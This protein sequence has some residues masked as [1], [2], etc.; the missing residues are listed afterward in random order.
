M[1]M[2]DDKIKCVLDRGLEHWDHCFDE[3]CG[4]VKG[5]KPGLFT[6]EWLKKYFT[7]ESSEQLHNYPKSLGYATGLFYAG[8]QVDRANRIVEIFTRNAQ[9]KDESNPDYGQLFWFLEEKCIRDRNA[10]FFNASALFV[11]YTQFNGLL[12]EGNRKTVEDV[13]RRL[14]PVFEKEREE[15]RWVY[16]N[17]SLGKFALCSLLSEIFDLPE[18]QSD[19]D[20]FAEFADFLFE[21]GVSETLT[22]TYVTVDLEILFICLLGS[23]APAMI[24]KARQLLL[25]IFLKQT[26]FFGNRFPAPFRRGYNGEYSTRRTDG[27]P[28]LMG[29]RNLD[30]SSQ[31]PSPMMTAI[32][33]IIQTKY[34]DL[35]KDEQDGELPRTLHTKVH[36]DCIAV[37]YLDKEYSLGSFNYYPPE[38]TN[39][40]TVDIGGSGWQD[41]I[42]Y[43]TLQ[44]QECTSCILRLEAIDEA[45]TERFHPYEGEYLQE[46]TLRLYPHLSFPP[47]PQIRCNQQGGELLCIYK[48]DSID[49]VLR[50]FGFNLHFSRFNGKLFDIS[51]C[52][53]NMTSA[54]TIHMGAVIMSIDG[55]FVMLVP[56]ARVDM[57]KSE[58]SH[59]SFIEPEF[60][61]NYRN[62]G[63]DCAMYNYNGEA[64]RFTL[65]HVSGG[66]FLSVAKDTTLDKFLE[67]ARQVKI[68]DNWFFD[69][70]TPCIDQ[71]GCTRKTAAVSPKTKLHLEWNHFLGVRGER[72]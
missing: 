30:S 26:C 37:S 2:T 1:H 25:Q 32:W 54:G 50:R 60:T 38:T 7:V 11:I 72:V 42:V 18:K 36:K 70:V 33:S 66:F 68:S 46:K 22:P 8:K 56:L 62:N 15:A 53:L 64:K 29:W 49:A 13:L 34:P 16:I 14:Y 55:V 39:W 59:S 31:P 69:K 21:T 12:T 24:E 10:N 20:K 41:G 48:T 27:I 6:A 61:L 23:R 19:L 40:Q 3:S 57:A 51:G 28:V 9:V 35:L 5:T 4:L 63:L 65:N 45:G 58:L 52:P 47:E 17:P 43:F 71:R 67:Y 44:N